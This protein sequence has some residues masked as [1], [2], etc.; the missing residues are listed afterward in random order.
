M[1]CDCCLSYEKTYSCNSSNDTKSNRGNR[2]NYAKEDLVSL[3]YCG[4]SILLPLL[5]LLI[6]NKDDI[7][8]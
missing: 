3:V 1:K 4:L 5:H 2:F 7:E 8:E 6:D